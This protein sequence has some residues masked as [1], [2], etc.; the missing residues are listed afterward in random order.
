MKTIK[1][2]PSGRR[3]A[4][5]LV[6]W[7][8]AVS[9]L[10]GCGILPKEEELPAAPVLAEG[11]VDEYV[12]TPV[13]RSDIEVGVNIRCTFIPSEEERLSFPVGGETI[14]HVYVSMGDHVMPGDLLMELDVSSFDDQIRAQQNVIDELELELYHL[15]QSWDL[16]LEA[17]RAEDEW[18]AAQGIASD[19]VSAVNSQ[20]GARQSLY[21]SG[22][23]VATLRLEELEKQ[24]AKRQIFAT[25]EGNVT[26]IYGFEDGESS[27]KGRTVVVITNME[28]ALFEVY[29]GSSEMIDFG[30]EYTLVCNDTEYMVIARRAEDLDVANV[31]EGRSYF[32]MEMP[33]PE[34]SQGDTGYVRITTAEKKNVLCV[35]TNAVQDLAGQTVVY[36]VDEEGLRQVQPVTTGIS[37]DKLTE[38]VEG[39]SEG[40]SVIL[41]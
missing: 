28:A 30:K 26:S 1:H 14:S 40:D 37:N 4:R 10:T 33:A 35:A 34:L 27:V 39:L 13:I 6:L 9:F 20:F 15:S 32:Q 41:R 36:I 5:F 21:Y 24:K 12:L 19:R 7:I 31:K 8:L 17:A 16:E 29:S 11:Q 25:I 38:I 18:N 2:H 3:W 22:Y 23:E